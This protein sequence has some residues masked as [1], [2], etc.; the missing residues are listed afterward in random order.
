MLVYVY[1]IIYRFDYTRGNEKVYRD[2][3]INRLE[4]VSENYSSLPSCTLNLTSLNFMATLVTEVS[5]IQLEH[6]FQILF[7]F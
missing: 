6:L 4:R 5:R 1:G 3:Q 2:V 7:F